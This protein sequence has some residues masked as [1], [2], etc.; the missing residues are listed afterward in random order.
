VEICAF[1]ASPS[2][3]ASRQH[4]SCCSAI[5]GRRQVPI[6]TTRPRPRNIL[7]PRE[8]SHAPAAQPHDLMATLLAARWFARC[9]SGV[10]QSMPSKTGTFRAR[11]AKTH[12][13]RCVS[14]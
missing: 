4:R 7:A 13:A 8:A 10:I 12:L 1:S 5:C 11:S 14:N 2:D 9:L 6:W 3:A